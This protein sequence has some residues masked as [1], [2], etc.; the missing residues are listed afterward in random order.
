MNYNELKDIG[1]VDSQFFNPDNI[2]RYLIAE[3]GFKVKNIFDICLCVLNNFD[4]KISSKPY[5]YDAIDEL[6]GLKNKNE[7]MPI[8]E[9]KRGCLS[10]FSVRLYN[11]ILKGDDY[12]NFDLCDEAF[13]EIVNASEK[14]ILSLQRELEA[15]P[16]RTYIEGLIITESQK[17][18]Y[19]I[20]DFIKEV[21]KY[22]NNYEKDNKVR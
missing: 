19:F 13:M 2:L 10:L 11:Y 12:F 20:D 15:Y 3:K 16:N 8:E 17:P 18:Y 1:L 4:N 9:S 21:I 6:K 5:L 14:E 7:I 22:L